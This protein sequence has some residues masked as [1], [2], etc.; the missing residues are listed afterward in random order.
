MA[1]K[2][3]KIRR[4]MNRKTMFMLASLII[5][6]VMSYAASANCLDFREGV[7][8]AQ[9]WQ[10]NETGFEMECFQIGVDKG[11]HT[12]IVAY[13]S[14]KDLTYRLV[15]M[16]E[17]DGENN[18]GKEI[19]SGT[20]AGGEPQTGVQFTLDEAA[21]KLTLYLESAD[22]TATPGY[23]IL[24]TDGSVY[25]DFLLVF[26]CA[27][28][29]I[30][31]LY[32]VSERKN[33]KYLIAAVTAAV[34][35]TL[36]FLN[37]SLQIGDDLEFHMTRIR[38]LAGAL[39]S[40]QF[41]VRLSTAFASGYGMSVDMMYPELFLYIP[42]VL[43]LAGIS[44]MTSYKFLIL[45]VNI[46]SACI[47]LYSFKRLLGSERYGLA[48]TLLWLLNPYRLVNSFFRAAVG[49]MLALVFLPL[50]L[51]G[52]YELVFG[53]ARKW[54]VSAIAATGIIQ[55]HIL[56]VEMS[57]IF[58]AAVMVLGLGS[59]LKNG[60]KERFKGMAKAALTVIGVNLWFL[61]PFLTHFG[62]GNRI[63]ERAT[64]LQDSAVDLYD[65]FHFAVKYVA[66]YDNG[67]VR[68]QEF[69]SIGPA[70]LLGSLL[71]VYYAFIRKTLGER[72]RKIGTACLGAGICSCYLATR[73]FPWRYI[74]NEME[75]LYDLLGII[76][77]PWRF[78]GYA[79]LFLSVVS[80]IAVM[81]LLRE[82]KEA[83]AAVMAGLTAVMA[84]SC[85][86]QYTTRDV[87]ISDRSEIKTYG[88]TTF[89]YYAADTDGAAIQDQGDRVFSDGDLRVTDYERNGVEVSFDYSGE[90]VSKLKLPIYDYGMH[91]VYLDGK[92]I[93][94]ANPENHQLTVE[95]PEEKASGHIEVRYQEPTVYVIANIVSLISIAGLA[96]ASIWKRRRNK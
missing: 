26:L 74:Q 51:Y 77:F 13:E 3:S 75:S 34:L 52:V 64:S 70:V 67:G 61:V 53:N 63:Q 56:S 59:I 24:E 30:F 36:P 40:G 28:A 68:R 23:W 49:E 55:S 83:M 79:A 89:D 37:G 42:A 20:L 15:D 33:G 92:E 1:E 78:L 95:I 91:V 44:L 90:G 17:N 9:E 29:G 81:E 47:G 5:V 10:Q 58:V 39:Q 19:I 71:F 87:Y 38:G 62:D 31:F 72:F 2:L 4:K 27:A 7:L 84:L 69:V 43:Y 46:A 66:P 96:A 32:F 21:E 94:P 50:L 22:N 76:Q 6:A 14:E 93:Q 25:S 82:K 65:V 86:D 60:W 54:Y 18:L 88:W 8:D 11:T 35:S 16:S 73:F 57:V 41:P 85:M 80:G 45:C 48:V 12:L